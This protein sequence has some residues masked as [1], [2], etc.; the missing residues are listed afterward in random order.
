MKS[1]SHESGPVVYLTGRSYPAPFHKRQSACAEFLRRVNVL[2]LTFPHVTNEE[3]FKVRKAPIYAG[4]VKRGPHIHWVF[5]VG[6]MLFDCPFDA[7]IIPQ[8][9][10]TLHDL[11]TDTRL[12]VSVH[13]VDTFTGNLRALREVTL[14]PSLTK[15]FLCDVVDQL[16]DLRNASRFQAE[17]EAIPLPALA[18]VVPT[19][20]CGL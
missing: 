12:L 8:D 18:K 20:R 6:G 10:L 2:Q 9:E 19:E 13:L 7:R 4:Y 16:A 3:E 14:S 15:R 11:A 17:L 5:K 1:E